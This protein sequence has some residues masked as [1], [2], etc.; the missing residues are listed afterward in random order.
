[1]QGAS[2]PLHTPWGENKLQLSS[3]EIQKE[4]AMK[5][6]AYALAGA[7]LFITG[8]NLLIA[9]IRIYLL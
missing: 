7:W 9:F 5:E 1:M 6:L 3:R 4:V 2:R 8:L